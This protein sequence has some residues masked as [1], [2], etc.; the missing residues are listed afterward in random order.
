MGLIGMRWR[1]SATD[2]WS[3]CT[4]SVSLV[5]QMVDEQR[6]SKYTRE[7]TLAH[8]VF[9]QCLIA[10]RTGQP[11]DPH[12]WVGKLCE[13]EGEAHG[14]EVPESMAAP[15]Q[16]AIDYLWACANEH[17]GFRM[18]QPEQEVRIDLGV[19]QE[20]GTADV[21]AVMNDGTVHVFDLKYG[22]GKFVHAVDNGQLS[23]YGIGVAQLLG[24]LGIVATKF[25]LHI[26]LPRQSNGFSRW[27]LTPEQLQ[28]KAIALQQA[29]AESINTPQYRPSDA[30]CQWCPVKANCTALT[31][32]VH[33]EMATGF[34]IE[35]NPGDAVIQP[36]QVNTPS[37]YT[38]D[39][40]ANMYKS[41]KL[42][43]DWC[44]A[45]EAAVNDD[46]EQDPLAYAGMLKRVDGDLGARKWASPEV[47]VKVCRRGKLKKAAYT[48]ESVISPTEFEKTV[49]KVTYKAV[50]QDGD[51]VRSPGAPKVVPWDHKKPMIGGPSLAEQFGV[52]QP[53][54]S[55]N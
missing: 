27:E 31:E 26:M 46:L 45:V 33:R 29:A 20:K 52:P 10:W 50:V 32:H 1:P 40:R 17:G 3:T 6:S 35:H 28:E 53:P 19:V 11:C 23:M 4:M 15:V 44:T 21:T 39:Q 54:T 9:E 7:G 42:I 13:A 43:R 49:G 34:I 8:W 41:L 30:A 47:A 12:L 38:K 51:V 18:L 14:M 16:E 25:V 37:R 55:E 24:P 36:E 22:A 2:R 5:A 48:K